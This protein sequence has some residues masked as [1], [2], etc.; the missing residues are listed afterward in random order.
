MVMPIA[1]IGPGIAS[2]AARVSSDSV[3]RR[4]LSRPGFLGAGSL[5]SLRLQIVITSFADRMMGMQ[6]QSLVDIQ[7]NKVEPIEAL[8][9]AVEPEQRA[10]IQYRLDR[11]GR[12]EVRQ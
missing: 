1:M 6:R 3:R 11:A 7:G 8:D 2:S 9:S 10:E 5:P 4:A 12:A